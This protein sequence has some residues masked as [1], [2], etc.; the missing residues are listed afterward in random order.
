[1]ANVFIWGWAGYG[2]FFLVAYK[3]YTMG[4]AMS[5]LSFCAYIYIYI[6]LPLHS[7]FP[8]PFRTPQYMN[9]LANTK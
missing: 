1:V 5:A 7:P 6:P 3:D 2:A 9:S 8:H 4:Y